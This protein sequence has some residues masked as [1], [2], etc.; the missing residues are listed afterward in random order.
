MLKKRTDR[1]NSLLVEVIS[2]VVREDVRNPKVHPLFTITRVDI[3][4][5]LHHSKVF[6]SVIGTQKEKDDTLSALQSAAGFIAVSASRKVVMR[7]FPELTFKLDNS[8][9]QQMKIDAILG[10]IHE[11]EKSRKMAPPSDT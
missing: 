8:V 3:S 10:K 4:T 9:D 5:D 7:H 1:L 11:E 6:V 2:E